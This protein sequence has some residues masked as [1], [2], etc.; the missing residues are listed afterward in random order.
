MQDKP[1]TTTE[2]ELAVKI[3]LW[4]NGDHFWA[5]DNPYPCH[6][7]GDPITFG[8][9][10]GYAYFRPSING[11]PEK[12]EVGIGELLG[13]IV[14]TCRDYYSGNGLTQD[15]RARDTAEALVDAVRYIENLQDRVKALEAICRTKQ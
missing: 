10:F 13:R 3:W 1:V 4:K 11:R 12:K 8:E 9:P 6:H 14:A 7:N 2:P 5:F 15:R